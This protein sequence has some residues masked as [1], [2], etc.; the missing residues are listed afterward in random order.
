[1]KSNH[2][3]YD[4]AGRV[5][6]MTNAAGVQLQRYSYDSYDSYNPRGPHP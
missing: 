6:T 2:L 3:T 1:V 4:T 5:T